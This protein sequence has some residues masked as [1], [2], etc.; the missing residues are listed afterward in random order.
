MCWKKPQDYVHVYSTVYFKFSPPTN[1]EFLVMT[2]SRVLMEEA[3]VLLIAGVGIVSGKEGQES[4]AKPLGSRGRV[5]GRWQ[6]S[7][8]LEV[9]L[10]KSHFLCGQVQWLASNMPLHDTHFSFIDSVQFVF[11]YWEFQVHVSL[12]L[13]VL[14]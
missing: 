12:E 6:H 10:R 5:V 11:Y 13:R 14:T 4:K 8:Q 2:C 1:W 3:R 9:W 7:S